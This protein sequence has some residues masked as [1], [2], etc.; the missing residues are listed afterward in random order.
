MAMV[1]VAGLLIASTQRQADYADWYHH[2]ITAGAGV[3]I[4][5]VLGT[6]LGLAFPEFAAK[7]KPLGD[8]FIKLIKMLIAPIVFCVVVAGICGAGEL[9]KVGRVAG[10]A[11]IYFL[12]L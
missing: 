6:V 5:L 7:L 3:L 2:W 8:A 4:A 9:K 10:K 12:L 1:A 11:M